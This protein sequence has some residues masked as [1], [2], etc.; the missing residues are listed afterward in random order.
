MIKTSKPAGEQ[1]PPSRSVL[2]L[3]YGRGP[4][5]EETIFS[6]LTAFYHLPPNSGYN[7]IVYT[8][9]PEA[10]EGLSVTVHALSRE[11]LDA[12]MGGSDYI[13]RRKTMAIIDA[14][15]RYGGDIAFVDCDTYFR[16]SPVRLFDRIG[17]GRTCLHV[18]EADLKHSGTQFDDE[19]SMAIT[20]GVFL[21][22]SGNPLVFSAD[23]PMW[24]SGV[25]GIN[26]ADAVLMD[27]AL[28][29]MD[30]LWRKI[31]VPHVE[32]FAT[33]VFF[34]KTR[35][36]DTRDI[37]FHYWDKRQREPFRRRLPHL[38]AEHAAAPLATRADRAYRD[39]PRSSFKYWARVRRRE[40]FR[41]LGLLRSA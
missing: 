13:H 12:W 38:L 6:L 34:Q 25:I 35:I 26:A 40:L 16:R 2:Y 3:S 18:L 27:E 39:R 37:V 19:L 9:D 8:D 7:Y 20:S 32:Q 21:D 14:L 31:R 22:K 10:F 5:V 36:S 29:L 1:S 30:Q 11:D 28:A 24:N 33:G 15:Q 17:P 41:R 4:H 23:A